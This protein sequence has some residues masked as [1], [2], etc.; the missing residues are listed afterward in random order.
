MTYR[1]TCLFPPPSGAPGEGGSHHHPASVRAGGSSQH[2]R[3]D[4]VPPH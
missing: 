4:E 2:P 1:R 3:H